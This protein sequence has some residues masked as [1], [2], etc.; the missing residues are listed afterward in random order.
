MDIRKENYEDGYY[1]LRKDIEDYPDAWLYVV[2]SRRGPGKTYSALRM[3]CADHIKFIYIKRT[4]EDV[5]FICSG[6][7]KLDIDPSPFV[8]LNRDF[9]INITAK[10]INKG[11]GGFYNTDGNGEIYGAPIGYILSLN[12]VKRVKGFDLSDTDMIIFDEFIPQP[13]EI[14]K[15]K[16]GE[17]LADLYM[18][19]SRDR[20][21]RGRGNLRLIMFAN[22]ESVATPITNTFELTDTIAAMK[23]D[24]THIYNEDR[25]ILIH[26]I[27]SKEIPIQDIEKQGIFVGMKGTAWH[28]KSFGGDFSNNDFSNICDMSIKGMQPM[29]EIKYNRHDYYIFYHPRRSFYYMTTSKAKCLY[30]YDLNKENDQKKFYI[31]FGL[32]LRVALAESRFFFKYYTMYDIINR[33][34]KYFII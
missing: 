11:F 4:N 22:S 25:Q 27:T 8:P 33:Y 24:Q 6:N 13:G 26:R 23:E 15:L 9:G 14:V 29:I 20:L 28:E 32:T 7:T 12:S 34:K 21:K 17:M 1:H 3:C 10:L 19:V 31:D 30:Q 18:T 16:E 5:D 2:F